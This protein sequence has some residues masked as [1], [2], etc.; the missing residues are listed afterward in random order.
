MKKKKDDA[1]LL[2]VTISSTPTYKIPYE[3]LRGLAEEFMYQ[4][5]STT[6]KGVVYTFASRE[7]AVGFYKC[8]CDRWNVL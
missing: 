4:K 3:E 8:I 5:S 1:S 7:D 6:D 2:T